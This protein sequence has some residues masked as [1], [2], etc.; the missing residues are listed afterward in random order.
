V[1]ETCGHPAPFPEEIP[2]RILESTGAKT[3][4]DPFMGSGT[5][6]A[7]AKRMGARY[8]GVEQS[9]KY[10]DMI[11]SRLARIS[12]HKTLDMFFGE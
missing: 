1:R 4:L 6:A 5:T 10:C 2:R 9:E 12:K 3:V 11:E 8:T 7:V